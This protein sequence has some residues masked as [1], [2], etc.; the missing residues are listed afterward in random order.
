MKK[1]QMMRGLATLLTVALLSAE[2]NLPVSAMATTD[3]EDE[4]VVVEETPV[5]EPVAEES[6]EAVSAGDISGGNVLMQTNDGGEAKIGFQVLFLDEKNEE[7]V[8]SVYHTIENVHPGKTVK[9]P[10]APK[11]RGYTFMGWYTERDGAGTKFTATTKVMADVQCYACWK[12]NSYKINFNKNGGSVYAAPKKNATEEELAYAQTAKML[13]AARTVLFTQ[14][15]QTPGKVGDS[16]FETVNQQFLYRK[17][18]RLTGWNTKSNPAAKGAVHYDLE[19]DYSGLVEK[20]KGS[21]T[22]YAEWTPIEYTITYV[23]Y[24]VD[25]DGNICESDKEMGICPVVLDASYPTIHTAQKNFAIKNGVRPGFTFSGWYTSPDYNKK[26]K[27][28]SIS[29][30]NLQDVTLYAKWTPNV[31]NVVYNANGGAMPK[32]S[33]SKNEVKAIMAKVSN[34]P[35][36]DGLMLAKKPALTKNGYDFTGWNT[37]KTVNEDYHYDF[38]DAYDAA[39]RVLGVKKNKETI[40]LYAEWTPVEYTITY[41]MNDD[42]DSTTQNP[43]PTIRTVQKAVTLKNPTREGY[44]FKGW[45]LQEDFSGKKQ[46]SVG[47][48]VYSDVVLYA[49]WAETVYTISFDANGGTVRDK[50][51]LAKRTI[52]YFD[53][54][55]GALPP[56]DAV[57]YGSAEFEGWGTRAD[58]SGHNYEP[59]TPIAEVIAK[60]KKTNITLYA[61]W[62]GLTEKNIYNAMIAMKAKYPEGMRWTND[63]FYAWKGGIYGG[64]YGCAGFAFALSDAAFGNLP[65]RKDTNMNN[66]RVGDILRI[67]NDTHS[68]IVLEVHSD[69]YVIAEGNYNSS[70]HWG[71][72]IT[73]DQLRNSFTYKMTRYPQ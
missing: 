73:K 55:K 27:I 38:E 37:K 16:K 11:Y 60:E 40:T 33:V 1:R 41:V 48:N 56:A 15:F 32:D 42:G 21:I 18:Y 14:S 63:N 34:Q 20:N 43:N 5:E 69:Y 8:D 70:I 17:G 25:A 31:Y 3:A 19:A 35:Y 58:G 29:K 30:S 6:T 23:K 47:K 28:T 66:I 44:T 67:N 72:T 53:E 57:S 71:R 36:L 64:G 62:G 7:L 52:S 22:L 46:T 54:D 4:I 50:N 13:M 9:L 12:E 59:G 51:A 45:Y 24:N 10:L 39:G 61:V 26:S 49:H 68:V 2:I 65:A